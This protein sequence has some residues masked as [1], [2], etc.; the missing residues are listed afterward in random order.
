MARQPKPVELHAVQGTKV[1]VGKGN[2]GNVGRGVTYTR[3]HAVPEPPDYLNEH[4]R[5]LWNDLAGEMVAA[6]IMQRTDVWPLRQLCVLWER[7]MAARAGEGEFLAADNSN[8]RLLFAEFGMTPAS[9][10]RVAPSGSEDKGNPFA[11][12]RNN[13]AA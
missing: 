5:E 3:I 10:R 11:G 13:T 8:M 6:G 2:R 4:G 12:F 9:R 1:K 7:F